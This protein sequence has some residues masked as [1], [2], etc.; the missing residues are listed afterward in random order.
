MLFGYLACDPLRSFPLSFSLSA[1]RWTPLCF[2]YP[3]RLCLVSFDQDFWNVVT[4]KPTGSM[5]VS[6]SSWLWRVLASS[7]YLSDRVGGLD[8]DT[9]EDDLTDVAVRVSEFQ[10]HQMTASAG[11]RARV[12]RKNGANRLLV[13]RPEPRR[14]QGTGSGD[15]VLMNHNALRCGLLGT[16]TAN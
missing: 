9:A 13:V 1:F 16:Q 3:V 15:L 14:T 8:G 11:F 5:V 6:V 4:S 7:R 12:C 2:D 10:L